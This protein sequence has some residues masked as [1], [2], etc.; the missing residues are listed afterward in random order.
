[1]NKVQSWRVRTKTKL[2]NGF[3]GKCAN[4]GYNKTISALSF[5]HLNEND[6]EFGIAQ[7]LSKIR[8]WD[9]IKAEAKKCVMLCNN[10][11]AEHHAGLFEVDDSFPRFDPSLIDELDGYKVCPTCNS[12]C[13][14][15]VEFCST[16]CAARKR[17]N[18]DSVDV[19]S[20]Y[21]SLGSYR[22]VGFELG[23]SAAAVKKRIEKLNGPEAS[24]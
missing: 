20:M 24:G 21:N 6:K 10:C 7:A 13:D 17:F 5:H 23:L 12:L 4:C 11:H 3:G 2:V 1:M 9:K 15:G 19:M 22:K 8:S 18:W 14:L 16:K